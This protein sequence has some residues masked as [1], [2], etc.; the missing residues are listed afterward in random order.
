MSLQGLLR[1]ELLFQRECLFFWS[2]AFCKTVLCPF[3]HEFAR[4]FKTRLVF[5]NESGCF[6]GL[7][8]FVRRCCALFSHEFHMNLQRFLRPELFFQRECLF[9]W[10]QAFCKTVLC[11]FSHEFA[12][13]FKTRIVFFQRE[14]C[15]L[16]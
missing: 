16:V 14:C 7:K 6:F 5:F 4:C 10:S 1:P 3:S 9:F 8:H 15:F 11:P 2:E 13:C 12:R